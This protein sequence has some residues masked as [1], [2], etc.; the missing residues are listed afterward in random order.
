MK[1]LKCKFCGKICGREGTLVIHE[2]ACPKN[3]ESKNFGKEVKEIVGPIQES[4][5]QENGLY[6]CPYCGKEFTRKG[7]ATHIFLMHTE[8]GKEFKS[9]ANYNM[10]G[11][12]SWN[13]GLTKASDIRVKQGAEKL[14]GSKH[15]KPI[16]EETRLKLRINAYKN[17]FGKSLHARKTN[18]KCGY[19]KDYQ[20]D[21]SW[22]LAFVIYCLEHN[23][24]IERNKIGFQYYYKNKSHLYYPDFK[25]GD[26]YYEIKG[27]I[28][29]TENLETKIKSFPEKLKVLYSEDLKEILSYVRKKYGRNFTYLYKS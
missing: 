19:Y 27:R 11:K 7:I 8:E 29:D 13:H 26:T 24:K 1:E 14:K 5:K 16:T 3:P 25:I 6:K 28:R 10:R 22:E 12:R 21:S 9:S 17:N 15:K 23:I 20:C 18:G 2:R 4:W